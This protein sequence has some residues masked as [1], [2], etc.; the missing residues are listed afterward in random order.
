M[1]SRS[2]R[3]FSGLFDAGPESGITRLNDVSA[4]EIT[5]QL[6]IYILFYVQASTVS[7][8]F[9]EMKGHILLKST[10]GVCRF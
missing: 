4:F 1:Q 8:Y 7:F 5:V 6:V 10:M 3:T 9:Q 2:L